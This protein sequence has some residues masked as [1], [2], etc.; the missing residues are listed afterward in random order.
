M[1]ERATEPK[2]KSKLYNL[3]RYTQKKKVASFDELKEVYCDLFAKRYFIAAAINLGHYDKLERLTKTEKQ[4]ILKEYREKLEKGE[5]K[6]VKAGAQN[7]TFKHLT[8][9][10]QVDP[11]TMQDLK[12]WLKGRGQYFIEEETQ[13]DKKEA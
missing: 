7:C 2:P 12:E 11:G 4:S 6:D 3:F 10:W 5:V 9:T 8:N 13:E 1:T